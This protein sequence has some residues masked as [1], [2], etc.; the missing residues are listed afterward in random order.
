MIAILLENKTK[1]IFCNILQYHNTNY[2]GKDIKIAVL[3]SEDSTHG[4]QTANIIWQVAPEAEI[5][6]RPKPS[7]RIINGRLD[8]QSKTKYQRFYNSLYNEGV[9]ILCESLQ[10]TSAEDIQV[11]QEELLL[12]K[13][14]YYVTSAGNTG[15]VINNRVSAHLPTTISVGACRLDSNKTLKRANY[16]SYGEQLDVYGLS[17]LYTTRGQVKDYNAGLGGMYQGTSCACPFFVGLLGLLLQVYDEYNEKRPD[18]DELKGLIDEYGELVEESMGNK[19]SVW[20]NKLFILPDIN[21]FKNKLE[22]ITMS[23]IIELWIC[24]PMA[25]INGKE[26]AIDPDDKNVFPIIQNDRTLIP[27]RFVA[28]VFNCNVTWD[29]DE[30]KITIRK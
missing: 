22:D 8:A 9:D 14:M 18:Y 10:G 19:E 2:K 23:K 26:V 5:L 12:A 20:K 11:K 15:E 6:Y 25:K 27:L 4:N 28:E 1:F 7:R 29:N 13:G 24:D 3:E 30:K 16:S 17:G 21:E